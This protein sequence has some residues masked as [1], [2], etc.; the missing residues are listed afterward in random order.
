MTITPVG[1]VYQEGDNVTFTCTSL[2]GP[3]NRIRWLAERWRDLVNQSSA[4]LKLVD[5]SVMEDGGI[6][7]CVAS[8]AVGSGSDD[9][10]LNI[11]P[12]FEMD[13]MDVETSNGSEVSFTCTALAFPEPT[14]TW[15]RVDSELPDSAVGANTSTLTLHPAVFGDQGV[16]YCNAT[17]S[18][19]SKMSDT[20]TLTSESLYKHYTC[21]MTSWLNQSKP[22]SLLN[23]VHTHSHSVN[24][25]QL[26]HS[27]THT[28]THT[29][30][31]I[32]LVLRSSALLCSCSF[33]GSGSC[34][35]C[36]GR[37]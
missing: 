36:S 1:V 8:N 10:S 13:P 33:G 16:Y 22:H 6:Y 27:L 25:T 11:S 9:V 35:S 7:T 5:I 34:L 3:N 28:H 4:I 29:H 17:S 23:H 21:Q 14:Y 2:G 37:C 32:C 12:V 15:S 26:K 19:V 18:E 31:H 24:H 20:A 30:T